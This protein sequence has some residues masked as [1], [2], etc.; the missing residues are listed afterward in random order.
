MVTDAGGVFRSQQAQSWTWTVTEA[1]SLLV[2]SRSALETVQGLHMLQVWDHLG[3]G[4][5]PPQEQ[6][7][8]YLEGC[9]SV[10]LSFPRVPAECPSAD[11]NLT[12]RTGPRSGTGLGLMPWVLPLGAGSA[13]TL[14]CLAILL[15][16]MVYWR[17]VKEPKKSNWVGPR[18]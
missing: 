7:T 16:V 15:A 2:G 18:P 10:D 6:G 13:V 17:W 14:L 5:P 9:A 11:T 8:G 3:S 12:L 1:A 4:S